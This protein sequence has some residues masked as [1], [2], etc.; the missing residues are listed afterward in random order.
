MSRST[1]LAGKNWPM[2]QLAL[3]T[4]LC[5]PLGCNTGMSILAF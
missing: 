5:A 1:A 4:R 2:L 3:R